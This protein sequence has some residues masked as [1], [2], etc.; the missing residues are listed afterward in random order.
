MKKPLLV[1][2]CYNP[3]ANS[4]YCNKDLYDEIS[5]QL[6]RKSCIESP[7][8]IIGDLNSRIASVPDFDTDDATK[9][10]DQLTS[11]SHRPISPTTRQNCDKTTNLMGLKL[12]DLCK[13]HDL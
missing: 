5:T 13:T 6:L 10:D 7:V 4:K 9:W 8:M 3:P 2:I 12:I 11:S 1:C